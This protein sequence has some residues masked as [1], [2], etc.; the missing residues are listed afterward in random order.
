MSL[1]NN[2]IILA[3]S[4]PRRVQLLKQLGVEGF[5][6]TNHFYDEKKIDR[7]LSVGKMVVELSQLKAQSVLE[8]NK[9]FKGFI[10]SGDTEVYRCG[11]NILKN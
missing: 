2:K 1:D 4:S 9:E 10:I 6:T 5:K 7:N 8:K 11:K 3:S